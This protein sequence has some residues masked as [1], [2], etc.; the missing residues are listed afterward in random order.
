MVPRQG[1]ARLYVGTGPEVHPGNARYALGNART[2][3][4]APG[5]DSLAGAWG[6]E[7]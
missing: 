3:A 4:R 5:S 1:G 6:R 7:R 2:I